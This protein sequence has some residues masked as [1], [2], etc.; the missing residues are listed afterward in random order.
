MTKKTNF[1][2][3]KKRYGE[4]VI[5]FLK[6]KGMIDS[7]YKVESD[8]EY[9]LIPI[10]RLSKEDVSK[11]K[12][13]G[14]GFSLEERFGTLL[15]KPKSYIKILEGKIPKHLIQKLPKSMDFIGDIC[16]IEL[17]D[18]LIEYGETIGDAIMET[19]KG[20]K[21]V[22]AKGG[23][24]SGE[25]RVRPLIHIAGEERTETT[26]RENGCTFKLDV[27]KVYFSP[28]LSF[29]RLRVAKKVSDK[30]VVFD[31]FSGVGPFSILI[32]KLSGAKVYASDINPWAIHYLKENIKLNKVVGRV[33]PIMGDARKVAEMLRGKVDRVVMNLPEMAKE[34]LKYA[35]ISLKGEGVIHYYT[36]AGG[37]DPI[38]NS[39]EEVY[40]KLEGWISWDLIEKR[41][42]K[43]VAPRKWQ[44][45][46]DLYVRYPTT[47]T[48]V[49]TV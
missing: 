20:I 11:I 5:R 14:I 44:V 25:V 41:L 32:A 31:M 17:D 46:L 9:L 42:V 35:V 10:K 43:E 1:L 2:R 49:S 45:A 18:E 40:E 37:R 8:E 21:C 48:G 22:F 29:E 39:L 15:E 6:D 33:Y 7:S 19:N 4:T 13:K 16:I 38:K 24:V 36:F 30:E 26:H 3:V 23:A 47:K 34:F 27:S 12:K 28:R